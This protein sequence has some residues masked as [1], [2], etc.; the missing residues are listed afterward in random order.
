MRKNRSVKIVS[1]L[2][3][4]FIL[5]STWFQTEWI[6]AEE[7]EIR[8]EHTYPET[9]KVGE[10]IDGAFHYI[11]IYGLTP[12]EM[13]G[14]G[15]PYCQNAHCTN[16]ERSNYGTMAD[17]NGNIL[18]S[19]S[20]DYITYKEGEVIV[21]FSLG[22]ESKDN[23]WTFENWNEYDVTQIQVEAPIIKHNA[24]SSVK[25]GDFIDFNTEI[26]NTACTDIKV[27]EY[28]HEELFFTTNVEVIEGQ[29]LVK[30]SAQDYSNSLH[31]SE[32]LEFSGIGTVKL[33]ITYIPT[34]EYIYE[35]IS[36]ED[37][38]VEEIVTIE[39]E[40]D[41]PV[42]SEP[43]EK[44][45]ET[46]SEQPNEEPSE[47]PSEEPSEE[48]SETPSEQPSEVPSEE[49]ETETEESY[50]VP[51]DDL[52]IG[53]AQLDVILEENVNKDVVIKASANIEFTFKKGSMTQVEDKEEYD[54]TTD[55]ETSY[56]NKE[57]YGNLVTQDN[58]VMQVNFHYSGKLPGEANI[59][60]T[61]GVD[62]AGMTLYYSKLCADGTIAF[63]CSGVVDE[64]GF[65]TVR[66]DSCSDYVLTTERVESVTE[67]DDVREED[68]Q[69]LQTDDEKPEGPNAWGIVA[70]VIVIIAI[71]AGISWVVYKK[72]TDKI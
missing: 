28:G 47:I 38:I 44:P 57:E 59:K 23:G 49:P 50:V 19:T 5:C 24:P 67:D 48:P 56:Q 1:G 2:L 39:V 70:I 55:I 25:V 62:K 34:I 41:K 54:F 60:I 66:Q 51:T 11:N 18:N 35:L 9:M 68:S 22:R 7:D 71:V 15:V 42:V 36:Y 64:N 20:V 45:S 61:V 13:C 4:I 63:I 6:K 37:G 21:F 72:K 30:Q 33:K 32:K 43:E 12:N 40:D 31:T 29:D 53:K 14:E 17:E 65:L 3:L 46:P 27:A 10:R 16:A 58:F 26:T 8:F 52:I 69:K